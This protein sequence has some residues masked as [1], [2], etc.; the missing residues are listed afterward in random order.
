[1][2]TVYAWGYGDILTNILQGIADLFST[3]GGLMVMLG[4]ITILIAFMIVLF[5]YFGNQRDP[6]RIVRFY[7]VLIGVWTLFMQVRTTVQVQDLQSNQTTTVNNVPWAVARPLA[8]FSQVQKTLAGYLDM[9]FGLPDDCKYSKTGMFSCI[10][11]INS[12]MSFRITDPYLYTS[13]NYFIQNCVYT[14]ILDGTYNL[15][16]LLTSDN[17]ISMFGQNLHPSRYTKV[18]GPSDC[19]PTQPCGG[20]CKQG[21]SLDCPTA[22][23]IIQGQ[24]NSYVSQAPSLIGALNMMSGS[25]VSS[26]LGTAPSYLL[27]A[28]QTGSN[29]LLQTIG[30]NHFQDAYLRWAEANLAPGLGYGVGSAQRQVEQTGI[31]SSF[32]AGKYLPVIKGIVAVLIAGL[33]PT[34]FILLLTPMA[35][36]ALQG[37]AILF[38]WLLTWTLGDAVLNAIVQVKL[39]SANFASLSGTSSITS[40]TLP[41]I[42]QTIMDYIAMAG[43]FYWL[44]PTISLMAS[45]GFGIYAMNSVVGAVASSPQSASSQAGSQTAMGNVQAGTMHYNEVGANNYRLG[46]VNAWNT[47]M[48]TSS[49]MTASALQRQIGNVSYQLNRT[50]V[51][52]ENLD[53]FLQNAPI[54]LNA[55]GHGL[56]QTVKNVLGASAR[57]ENLTTADGRITSMKVV[58]ADNSSIEYDG[59]IIKYT[60]PKGATGTFSIENG[61]VVASTQ[62]SIGEAT[63]SYLRQ[64]ANIQKAEKAWSE[65]LK[66]AQSA[67]SVQQAQQILTNSITDMYQKGWIDKTT[68]DKLLWAVKYS[69]V[70]SMG[71][72]YAYSKGQNISVY[73]RSSVSQEHYM[74]ESAGLGGGIRANPGVQNVATN[75]KNLFN[76]LGNIARTLSGTLGLSVN[77]D[78]GER[79]TATQTSGSETSKT[80]QKTDTKTDTGGMQVMWVDGDV[81]PH[82]SKFKV[83]ENFTSRSLSTAF[84]KQRQQIESFVNQVSKETSA[85]FQKAYSETQQRLEQTGSSTQVKGDIDKIASIISAGQASDLAQALTKFKEL[86]DQTREGIYKALGDPGILEQITKTPERVKKD[87]QTP[88]DNSPQMNVKQVGTQTEKELQGKKDDL[89][90]NLR[91]PKEERKKK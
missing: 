24:L 27:N 37:T 21:C 35:I 75:A 45:T 51:V 30:I 48:L 56:L 47:S 57:I 13:L 66:H 36:R 79:T 3:S 18:Y 65:A 28:S 25:A 72:S 49:F 87:W 77:K 12:A 85:I 53:K 42:S 78:A 86:T 26:I 64:M 22:W 11:V 50:Q 1:M 14:N 84:S 8:F 54:G 40:L 39:H 82:E 58:G 80:Y 43:Q 38:I 4:K 17:I 62:G 46:N 16:D 70:G 9:A 52:G 23:G 90:F 2:N 61:K 55:F 91:E 71:N 34:L 5:S 20:P 15:D 89:S 73:D 69:A 81:M 44:V 6:L 7:I 31:T 68:H 59:N 67:S 32:M 19:N 60:T 33:T 63:L 74:G 88:I 41:L 29:L 76:V 10:G 83:H